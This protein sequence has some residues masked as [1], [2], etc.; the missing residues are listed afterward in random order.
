MLGVI[1][2]FLVLRYLIAAEKGFGNNIPTVNAVILFYIFV[3]ALIT[4]YYNN[5][6]NL[7]KHYMKI[8]NLQTNKIYKG[9]ISFYFL[10]T[11]KNNLTIQNYGI[12]Y[13][14]LGV[15]LLILLLFRNVNT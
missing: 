10:Q 12:A 9:H 8:A 7:N 15:L 2:A 1:P 3:G 6:A 14:V 5:S 13:L 4:H 11:Y